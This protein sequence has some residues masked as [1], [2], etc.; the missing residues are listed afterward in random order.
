MI[1]KLLEFEPSKRL[2]FSG[3][4]EIKKHPFFE[5]VNWDEYMNK[6]PEPPL[7]PDIKGPEDLSYFGL[8]R[9]IDENEINNEQ[10]SEDEDKELEDFNYLCI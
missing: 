7:K 3:V 4:E 9:D 8:A 6:T 2:G 5:G 10:N 1:I